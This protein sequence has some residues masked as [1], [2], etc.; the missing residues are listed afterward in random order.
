[1]EDILKIYLKNI[2]TFEILVNKAMNLSCKF[3][4]RRVDTWEEQI[5]SDI[6][7]R[8]CTI[9][10]SLLKLIPESE[11]YKK[12]NAIKLWDYSSICILSRTLLDSYLIFY[13]Y[14]ID[15]P[16][17]ENERNFKKLFWNYYN[18]YKSIK[19]L[20]LMKSQNS[21]LEI[22]KERKNIALQQIENNHYFQS[23]PDGIKKNLKKCIIFKIPN[24]ADIARKASIDGNFY[25]A[26]NQY[27]S[28]YIHSDSFCID[29]IA[30]FKAGTEDAYR[31][32]GTVLYYM[33]IFLSLSIRDFFKIFP[34]I[35]TDIDESILNIIK[36]FEK[37]A[38]NEDE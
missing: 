9:S 26:T 29:Q 27:L 12:I 5:A 16:S 28:S 32:I 18:D 20:D 8:I 7:G 30:I 15:I 13:H 23:Q 31:L 2:K 17:D 14:C 34:I 4:R 3:F 6:F 33:I 25:Y 35:N 36:V 1:M 11:I 37:L 24:N 19:N 10:F 22:I 21:Y 38:R